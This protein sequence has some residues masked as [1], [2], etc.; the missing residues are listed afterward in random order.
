MVRITYAESAWK[1]KNRQFAGLWR[2]AGC[3]HFQIKSHTH[4]ALGP[5]RPFGPCVSVD[6]APG[7]Y[8]FRRRWASGRA[9][10]PG[11][12]WDKLVASY[13][14][15]ASLRLRGHSDRIGIMQRVNNS[16]ASVIYITQT[17]PR[18]QVMDSIGW[19]ATGHLTTKSEPA[20][21]VMR[22]IGLIKGRPYTLMR[23]LCDTW[24]T[25]LRAVHVYSPP[26]SSRRFETFTWLITSSWMVTYWPTRNLRQYKI[27]L[28]QTRARP[29][30]KQA[31]RDSHLGRLQIINNGF[32]GGG[33]LWKFDMNAVARIIL[34]CHC[35]VVL[36]KMYSVEY[37][38]LQ[39][40]R[41]SAEIR[42]INREVTRPKPE[43]MLRY[44]C[45]RSCS[46]S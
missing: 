13:W 12:R 3:L 26:S 40:E 9:E 42:P 8:T 18:S 39:R 41:A 38:C 30:N 2:L 7:M 43:Y 29:Q 24:A 5:R 28:T 20:T 17:V 45:R 21:A 15:A 35:V 14:W 46:A 25:A 33:E 37:I 27:R 4:P 23:A 31:Q 34:P 36:V 10:S 6:F 32:G 19:P 16:C 11:F 1:S 22:G 44:V